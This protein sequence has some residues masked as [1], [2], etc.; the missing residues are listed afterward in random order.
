MFHY[1]GDLHYKSGLPDDF[2]NDKY[3]VPMFEGLVIS[4][5]IASML[6]KRDAA[7]NSIPPSVTKVCYTSL[8]AF[9]VHTEL[10]F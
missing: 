3:A 6:S 2:L 1:T 10:I 8:R 9:I 7:P 4:Q 5:T